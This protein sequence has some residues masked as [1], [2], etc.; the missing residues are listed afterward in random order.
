[1]Q[2]FQK[3]KSSSIYECGTFVLFNQFRIFYRF[4]DFLVIILMNPLVHLSKL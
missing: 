3:S 2:H 1:M 4:Q